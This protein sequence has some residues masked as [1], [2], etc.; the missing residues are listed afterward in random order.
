VGAT[1]II[2]L[3]LFDARQAV[4]EQEGVGPFLLKLLASV[5]HRQNS[6]ELALAAAR[7]VPVRHLHLIP[8]RVVFMWDFSETEKL[9]RLG[10]EQTR[11]QIA[12]WQPQSFPW[13]QRVQQLLKR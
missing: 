6:M 8:E 11:A 7:G 10:Y 12:D 3:D 4:T 9:F 5:E 1:D 2:A 13:L